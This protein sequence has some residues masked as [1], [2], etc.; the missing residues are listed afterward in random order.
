MSAIQ[1]SLSPRPPM[2]SLTRNQVTPCL[3]TLASNSCSTQLA[4][5]FL[6]TFLNNVTFISILPFLAEVNIALP[7]ANVLTENQVALG[8]GQGDVV[9]VPFFLNL[10]RCRL[11]STSSAL[12]VEGLAEDE[13]LIPL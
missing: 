9:N 8:A 13:D 6:T 12:A 2:P 11:H 5:V 3:T 10:S 1:S 7:A 4:T